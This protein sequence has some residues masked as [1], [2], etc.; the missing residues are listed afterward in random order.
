MKYMVNI[1]MNNK[2]VKLFSILSAA[3]RLFTPMPWKLKLV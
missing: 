2:I 3:N 1:R